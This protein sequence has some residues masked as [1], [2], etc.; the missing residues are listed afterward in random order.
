MSFIAGAKLIIAFRFLWK[1]NPLMSQ[2]EVCGV[3]FS[4]NPSNDFHPFPTPQKEPLSPL[5]R[6][7]T[8][9]RESSEPEKG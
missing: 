2:E 4:T 8:N 1:R 5:K 7:P 6:A 9:G 3:N